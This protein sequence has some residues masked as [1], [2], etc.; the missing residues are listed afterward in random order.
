MPPHF[1]F[2][3]SVFEYKFKDMDVLRQ[4]L[5]HRS[6]KN[7]GA[8]Y[9]RLEFLGDRVLGLV[10]A[11][12]LIRRFPH[13]SEGEIARRHTAL[14]R[15]ETLA[16]IARTIH[17]NRHIIASEG[18]ETKDSVLAD[19]LESCIGAIYY[20]GGFD[21]IL[22]FIHTHFSP[23]VEM[24]VTG[25]KDSKSTLQEWSQ[26]LKLGL[27]IYDM[28]DRSGSDHEPQFVIQVSVKGYKNGTGTGNSKQKASQ[29]A[30]LD[31]IDKNGIMVHP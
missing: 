3:E 27:P 29:N 23:Q 30:A 13:A 17:L 6:T 26:K 5:T 21:G 2:V 14:V 16:D 1:D 19:V 11:D 20:D 12:L 8:N 15:E 25:D 10:I 31:F 24:N 28:I 9:E 4:A 22:P 18:I 7:K